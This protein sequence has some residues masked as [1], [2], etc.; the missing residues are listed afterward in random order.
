MGPSARQ[1]E[2]ELLRAHA[3]RSHSWFARWTSLNSAVGT[4]LCSSAN[5]PPAP[6]DGS[7]AWSPTSTSLHFLLGGHLDQRR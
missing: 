5:M 6:I 2:R 7:C 3:S 1:R 4:W